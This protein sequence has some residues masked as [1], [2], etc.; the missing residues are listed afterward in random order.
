VNLNPLNFAGPTFVGFFAAILGS[1]IVL[2]V[3]VRF[4]LL[5]SD[6]P[7][8][9]V[10]GVKKPLGVYEL[11]YLRG[12]EVAVGQT[13]ISE[14]LDRKLITADTVNG[15]F[16]ATGMVDRIGHSLEEVPAT[17][18]RVCQSGEGM[19]P[20]RL[21]QEIAF[22]A[23]RIRQGLEQAGLVPS[24]EAR[25]LVAFSSW[26]LFGAIAGLGAAK[27]YVGIERGKPVF[28]LLVMV[29][30]AVAAGLVLALSRHTHRDGQRRLDESR[31]SNPEH[32]R[33]KKKGK[34]LTAPEIAQAL[35]VSLRRI[36]QDSDAEFPSSCLWFLSSCCHACTPG[37]QTASCHVRFPKS[38]GRLHGHLAGF[39]RH[40]RP[41]CDNLRS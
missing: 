22:L 38:D 20:G 5:S 32:Q 14:L 40:T 30:A 31:R 2:Q 36:G 12:K 7:K 18:L 6:G 39:Y 41:N 16:R 34:F 25:W 33:P 10:T 28:Y 27:I 3:L 23:A 21:R 11:A 26:G 4:W 9:T 13:G 24:Q 15:R 17:L 35:G 8:M 29:V 37:S 1:A 19:A